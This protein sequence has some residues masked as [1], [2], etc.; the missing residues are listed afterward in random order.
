M[1]LGVLILL[2]TCAAAGGCAAGDGPVR[3]G[4]P[5][6]QVQLDYGEPDAISD[7][8]GD[9]ARFYVPADR[10]AEEWPWE[11][12]RTFYYLDRD[13]AVT[14]RG[15]RVVRA[16]PI[17]AAVREHSLLPLLRRQGSEY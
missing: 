15:G 10:P 5:I 4:T 11:A 17:P 6:T 1:R 13:L 8:S 7:R 3:R 14:F 16:G 9:L 2:C 12:P